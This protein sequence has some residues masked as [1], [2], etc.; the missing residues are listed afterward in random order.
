MPAVYEHFHTVQSDEIDDLG[1]ASNV[2][3]LEWTQAAAIA[4]S[5][6]QGWSPEDYRQLGSGFV[7]RSHQIEYLRPA[8]PGED[9]V[10]RTWVADFRGVS[11]LRKYRIA[12]RHG[13]ELLARAETRWAF[14]N[15]STGRPARIPRPLQEAFEVVAD[16]EGSRLLVGTRLVASALPKKGDSPRGLV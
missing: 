4:H 2:V 12:R 11:S 14:V 15:L 3:Y 9:I 13:D 10:V 16:A 1:H 8:L 7:V 6:A 5:A